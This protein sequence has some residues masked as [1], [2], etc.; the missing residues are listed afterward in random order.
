MKPSHRDRT[1]EAKRV[2]QA[3]SDYMLAQRNHSFAASIGGVDTAKKLLQHALNQY[4]KS[5]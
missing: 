2:C 4:E 5:E 3:A 1:I